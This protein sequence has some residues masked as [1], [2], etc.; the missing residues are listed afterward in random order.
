MSAM[1]DDLNN[2]ISSVMARHEQ[3]GLVTKWVALIETVADDGVFGLWTATSDGL[4]AWDT[5][6]M[7]GH[8]LDLQRAKTF[9]SVAGLLDD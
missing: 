7:L 5:V 9:A 2:A 1:E 6:G 4:K 8:G 3:G